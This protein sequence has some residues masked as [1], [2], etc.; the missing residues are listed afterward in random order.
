MKSDKILVY[1]AAL[2]ATL[3][4]GFSFVWFKQANVVYRP[5]SI[6]TMRLVIAAVVLTLF[7]TLSKQHQKI[8]KKD[9]KFFILIALFE[10]FC[11]F[12]FESFGLTMV[13][14]TAAAIIISTIPLFTPIFTHFI[15]REKL[16]YLGILGLLISFGGVLLVVRSDGEGA[17]SILGIMLMFGAVF[18]AIFYGLV[19]KKLTHNY[20]GLTIVKYQN[21]FG[22]ILFLPLFLFVDVNHF[23]QVQPNLEVLTTIA[24]LAIF[25]STLS[26]VFIAYV[27]KKIG[28][29]NANIF[30]NLIPAFTAVIAYFVLQEALH[31]QKVVG[32]FIVISGVFISQIPQFKKLR[33][34][35]ST[36][37]STDSSVRTKSDQ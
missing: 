17:N 4:W 21:L 7:M 33:K 32:I 13:T 14:A 23:L 31:F 1:G 24:K 27:V 30:A 36:N 6:I 22:L 18:S 28:L 37:S 29:I 10:P 25:P 19:L 8:D 20:S 16:G 12:L 3:F 35:F 34:L 5:I 9:W 11:Y 15:S 2:L 26:F